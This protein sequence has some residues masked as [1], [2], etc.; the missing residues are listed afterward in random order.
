MTNALPLQPNANRFRWLALGATVCT[1]LLIILGGI[2]RVTGSGLGCGQYWPLCNG[3]WFPA[4]DV[5]TFI[6]LSH[7]VVTGL[8]TPLIQ[9]SRA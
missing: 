6:E 8:V 7:R 2:V 3:Q 4:L 9:R 5:S 1:F